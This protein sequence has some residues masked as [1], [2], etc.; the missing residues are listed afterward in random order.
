MNKEEILTKFSIHS[1]QEKNLQKYIDS[2]IKY[3]FHTNLVGK[4][5]LA[6]PWSKH[7]LDSLQLISFIKN[8]GHSIL[9]MGTGAG[10]PGVVLS[11]VGYKY[12]TL[13]DSNGLPEL[14]IIATG[15][16][17]HLAVE[18]QKELK[19]KGVN[20]RV[21]SMPSWELFEKQSDDY[22]EQVL[23]IAVKKR[24]S[25]EAASTFGWERYISFLNTPL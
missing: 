24:V 1:R 16:E 14:I 25:V 19:N 21:V 18:A 4:S 10:F 8:K 20:V 12:I 7:I 5:T 17:L 9:D 15:S 22:K 11:I 23:P 6:D 3:N 2:I 13:V